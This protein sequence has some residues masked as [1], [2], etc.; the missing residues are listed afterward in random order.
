[1]N[2]DDYDGG[3]WMGPHNPPR[4]MDNVRFQ[5]KNLDFLS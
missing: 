2:L 3:V 1:M 5:L 4:W